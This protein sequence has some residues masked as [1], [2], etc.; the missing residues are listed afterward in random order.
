M[1]FATAL[2]SL[3]AAAAYATAASVQFVTLDAK[4]RTIIFTPSPGYDKLPDVVV[5][6][7]SAKTVT[8][9][10]KWE[11]NYYAVQKGAADKPGM[12][13]EVMFGGW[14]GKTYFDVSA[15]VDPSDKDNV[16]EMWPVMSKTP[17]SGCAEHPC[18]NV[19]WQPDDVQTKVTDEVDL[20]QTLGLA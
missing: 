19:Y 17:T 10:D 20:V 7:G 1:H 2:F 12:L 5:G 4:E 16:M 9:P 8:F 13:G 18:N 11:G 15:I 3:V 6:A 14:L